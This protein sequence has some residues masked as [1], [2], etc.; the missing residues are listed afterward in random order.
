MKWRSGNLLEKEFRR[1]IVKI[2]QDL[3]K[4]TEKDASNVY[5]RPRKTKKTSK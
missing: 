2:I 4:R 5:Q 3:E 1:V